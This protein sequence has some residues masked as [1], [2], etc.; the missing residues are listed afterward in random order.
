MALRFPVLAL[1]CGAV[2]A[3]APSAGAAT[4]LQVAVGAGGAAPCSPTPCSLPDAVAA[5]DNGDTIS[6][7]AGT[8]DALPTLTIAKR[9][10]IAGASGGAKPVLRFP[11]SF[12]PGFDVTTS[13]AKLR[14]LA[15]ESPAGG[16]PIRA[17]AAVTV[18]DVDA[19]T[20]YVCLSIGSSGSVIE[21]STFRQAGPAVAP[22]GCVSIVS[23]GSGGTVVRNV[24][25][26]AADAPAFGVPVALI[27]GEGTTVDRLVVAGPA[28]RQ[29]MEF[30]GGSSGSAEAVMRRSRISGG[31][32]ALALGNDTVVT[33]TVVRA[34]DASAATAAT[35]A[36]GAVLRNVTA[37]AT[38]PG[39][40][41][42]SVLG[43]VEP[44]PAPKTS[45]KN[46][47][48]RGD[49]NDVWI[50]PAQPGSGP[51]P[52]CAID[53]FDPACSLVLP[54]M[55]A[56]N[57]DIGNS[58]FRNVSGT[59]N[60][61]SGSNQAAD[62]RFSDAAAGNFKPLAGSPLIDA[63]T[64]DPLNGALDIDGLQRKL[65]SAVDIG[66]FEF[67]PPASP[68]PPAPPGPPSGST[69]P[70]DTGTPVVAPTP[71]GPLD[72]IAPSL[73]VLGITNKRF[74]VG[75]QATPVAARA[76]R[77]KRGTAFVYTLSEPATVAIAIQRAAPGR[78]KG[79]SCVKPSRKN[80]RA[81]KCTRFTTV[82][83]I[84]RNGLAGP[85]AVPFSG[86]IGT[87]ALRRGKHRA[88][89]KARDHAGNAST[90]S[91]SV[92]FTVVKR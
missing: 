65:G 80:R 81:K 37:I 43:A 71:A 52:I 44:G 76:R 73:R 2:L 20:P 58:N 74:V 46:S 54:G 72:R 66:A 27:T 7:A 68:A 33:D 6:I 88:Q 11:A 59:L 3:F 67:A 4:T 19:T 17:T 9:V 16:I 57:L 31:T 38:G 8:Y 41:G 21:N 15:I 39:S 79:R 28:N 56:G 36:P 24:E 90:K 23:A 47:V 1:A 92:G 13:G 30:R 26:L 85:N 35:A 32:T 10:D 83:T 12:D 51:D 84:T 48:F 91:P 61:S 18:D 53:P 55:L 49:G 50:A 63:G 25:V 60:S 77:A 22:A 42:L 14:N 34:A 86:R 29:A 40:N 82:G 69:G 45:V 5:A 75:R 89:L 62:P 70:S 64:D 87:E 78:R